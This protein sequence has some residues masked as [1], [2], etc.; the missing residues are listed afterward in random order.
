MATDIETHSTTIELSGPLPA[1][2]AVGS[3]LTLKAKVSCSAGCDLRGLTVT[4]A[5]PGGVVATGTVAPVNES[6]DI[7]VKT[8]TRV[9]EPVWTV[10]FEPHEASGIR[11]EGSSLPVTIRT[12]AQG[13]SLAVWDIPSPVVM[14]SRFAIKAGAKSAADCELKDT[15]IEVCDA[16]GAVVA[17]GR[18]GETPWPGT[19]ALYWTTAELTAPATEGLS[20][21]SVRFAAAELELPHDG[22]AAE[23]RVAVVRPPEHRLTVKVV[24]KDSKVPIGD[25]QIRLGAYGAATGP[26]G[27]AEIMMPKGV[28]ELHVWKAGYE[29]PA[30]PVEIKDDI[31]VEVEATVV[32][33]DD[34]DAAWT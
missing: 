9:G 14:G 28:H 18:L 5:A 16:N 11:H 23:F 6:A 22:S 31:A 25:V 32:P 10:V 24:E 1:E 8:P 4:V 2:V 3:N 33:E 20:A 13:T 29:A 19:T 27:T 17:R 34:P 21:W 15:S 12:V 30:R 7:D 26:S